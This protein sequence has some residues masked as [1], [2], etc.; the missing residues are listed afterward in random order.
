MT[1]AELRTRDFELL[2]APG[3][4]GKASGELYLDDGDSLVQNGTTH[5]TFTY[6][7]GKLRA[8]GT[9]GYQTKSKIVKITILGHR[10]SKKTVKI[11][12]G[13]DFYTSC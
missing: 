7:N 9:Y 11:D 6:S 13:K 12:L 5:V 1:T 10:G 2:I 3:S 8:K 4:N